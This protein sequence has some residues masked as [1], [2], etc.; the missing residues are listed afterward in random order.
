MQSTRH[1]GTGPMRRGAGYALCSALL[2]IAGAAFA[3]SPKGTVTR[4][5]GEITTAVQ[6]I[7]SA[8]PLDSIFLG[9]DAATQISYA[10]DPAYQVFPP[11]T[12][13]G[14]Y[15]TFI[16]VDDA[17]YAPDFSGHGSSATGSIGIYTAFTPISQSGVSGSGTSADPFTVTTAVAVGATGLTL[18]HVDK[19]VVGDENYRTDATLTN[20][21][22]APVDAILYRAM[23]CYLGGTDR[24][25]GFVN[26][27]AVGCSLNPSNTPPGRI[28]QLV[29]LSAG[30]AYFEASYSQVWSA[31]GTHAPFD[32]T[33]RCDEE[34]DNGAGISWNV[35]VPANGS[36]T[37]SHLTVFSPLGAQALFV[38]KTADQ[39]SADAGATDGYTI[40]VSNPNS[41]DATLDSIID[42]LPAGFT[43]TTGSSSGA[44]T[45][46]PT[47]ASQ[48][49]TWAGPFQVTANGTLSLHFSVSV[50]TTNGTYYNE[51]TATG[52]ALTIAG[53]GPTAPITV[54][55]EP[56]PP[57]PPPQAAI[58]TPTLG[59]GMLALLALLVV[60][61]GL[62]FSR[63]RLTR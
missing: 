2:L 9:V 21:G 30:N 57:P 45:A 54:G 37:R 26:G 44:T 39:P 5:P 13:P 7:T 25:Y 48:I 17:L 60:G 11:S 59:G 4:A 29:P 15:G 50:S 33:C 24:G 36:I 61:A 23:D 47:I 28:E 40:V 53:S 32:N 12:T 55:G 19:Y 27:T 16:V 6:T 43:Y 8:G 46:D 56:P 62:Y 63:R 42:T 52:A 22:G 18:T 35:T 58:P 1:T 31:I 10:G 20:A 38:T 51:A 34:I 3:S 14:D 49:L 41:A